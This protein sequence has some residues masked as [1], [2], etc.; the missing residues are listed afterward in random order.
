M[1]STKDVFMVKE[2]FFSIKI[3]TN[4]ISLLQ[5]INGCYV[6]YSNSMYVG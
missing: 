4:I 1:V 5:S 6:N 3:T 2:Y